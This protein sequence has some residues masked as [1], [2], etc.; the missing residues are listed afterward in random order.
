VT[1]SRLEFQTELETLTEELSRMADVVTS[2]VETATSVIRKLD[3]EQAR[4]VIEGD[5]L[6]DALALQLE[7][8]CT[9][10]L[11]LQAPVASDLR[12]IVGA[13]WIVADFERC[14]DLAVNVVKAARRLLGTSLDDRLSNLIEHMGIE[15]VGLLRLAADAYVRRDAS[16]AAAL[17]D[18]DDR[19]D[20]L[21]R[22]WLAAIFEAHRTGCLEV[23]A[24]VQLALVGR[25]YE[26]LGDHAVN[27]GNRVVYLVT[28]WLP[29]HTGAARQAARA[30]LRATDAWSDHTSEPGDEEV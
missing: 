17:P 19:L 6:V 26:R 7:E 29:E 22:Q 23:E 5:D 4:L 8:R 9:R 11:A 30:Q 24:G 12:A 25:Y 15:A 27:V 20:R 14:G 21:H 3:L 18:L 10:L 13:L 28:G 16:V 1:D 2:S